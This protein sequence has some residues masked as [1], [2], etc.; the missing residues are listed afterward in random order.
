MTL[1][2]LGVGWV[3]KQDAFRA[4]WPVFAI[5]MA[6]LVIGAAYIPFHQILLQAGRPATH[7]AMISAAVAANIL[8]NALLIPYAQAIGAAL[9]TATAFVMSVLL[10]RVLA[11]RLIGVKL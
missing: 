10:L 6:G 2:P 1:Y 8:L 9:A 4:S 5:L 7:T 3:T 11:R